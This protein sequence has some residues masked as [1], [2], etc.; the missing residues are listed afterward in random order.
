MQANEG[1]KTKN[2]YNNLIQ[3]C[4]Y[5]TGEPYKASTHVDTYVRR[6]TYILASAL[7]MIIAYTHG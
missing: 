2:I 3:P 7:G 6:C 1:R 5:R 4:G